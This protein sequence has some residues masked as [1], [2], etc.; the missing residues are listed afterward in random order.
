MLELSNVDL[1]LLD[2]KIQQHW[3][4]SD[5]ERTIRYFV[6]SK[7]NWVDQGVATQTVISATERGWM[8][9]SLFHNWFKG[10]F[11]KNIGKERPI[12]LIY[13]GHSTHISTKLIR[14]AQENQVTIMKLPPHTTDVLQPLDVAIFKSLKQK[15]DKE[16]CKWQRQNPRKKIPKPQF[17]DILTKAAQEIS[18]ASSING[19]KATAIYSPDSKIRGPNK[20]AIPD[21]ILKSD[22]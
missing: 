3:C 7:E 22:L 6:F 8:E 15:W 21:S 12:L 20:G 19:F 11:L 1:I 16:L 2:E 14:L 13:G 18:S 4:T 9:T 10:V 5:D 17:T